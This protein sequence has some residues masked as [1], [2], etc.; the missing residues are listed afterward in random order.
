MDVWGGG[1]FYFLL[2]GEPGV[3]WIWGVV[4]S[5]KL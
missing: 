5:C 1:S 4:F 2:W 3:R